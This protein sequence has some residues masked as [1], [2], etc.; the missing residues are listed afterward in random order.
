M[1]VC[2][3]VKNPDSIALIIDYGGN[4]QTDTTRAYRSHQ[5]VGVLDKPGESDL[6]CDVDFGALERE[7]E[8]QG[9]KCWVE[10]QVR[11]WRASSS[12]SGLGF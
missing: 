12:N 1:P 5:Q 6:T 11:G 3:V 2:R 7:I 9:A 8:R 4:G 10:E